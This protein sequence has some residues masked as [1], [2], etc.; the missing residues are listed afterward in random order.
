MT[1]DLEY[2]EVVVNLKVIAS[3]VINS[4]LYTKGPYYY[5]HRRTILFLPWD[6][7][8]K[9]PKKNNKRPLILPSHS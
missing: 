9:V 3:V 5:F 8:Q 1:S 4:K 2:D 7:L 6:R